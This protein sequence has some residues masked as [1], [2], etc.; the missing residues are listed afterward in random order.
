MAFA[1]MLPSESRIAARSRYESLRKRGFAS[2]IWSYITGRPNQLLNLH[3]IEKQSTVIARRYAGTQVV[4]IAQIQGSEGR[5]K[6]FNRNFL[7]LKG[8]TEGRWINIALACENGV[9]LPAIE[10]VQIDDVYFIRDGHHRVS[11]AKAN[12]QKEIDAHVT[13]WHV[14]ER[15]SESNSSGS[16]GLPGGP[17]LAPAA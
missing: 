13:V 11:V 2:R 17:Q 14:Q 3:E 9:A 12:G 7:P 6:D 4:P 8:H 15:D 1:S 10:V 5:C 16:F